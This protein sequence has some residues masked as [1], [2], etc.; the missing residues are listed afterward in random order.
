MQDGIAAKH[1]DEVFKKMSE[2]SKCIHFRFFIG[3]SSQSGYFPW[4]RPF[5]TI[6]D[7]IRLQAGPHLY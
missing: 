5:F 6:L 4:S 7:T 3:Q 1:C 2:N